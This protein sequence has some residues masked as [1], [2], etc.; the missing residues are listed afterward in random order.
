MMVTERR[1]VSVMRRELML[2]HLLV[3][4]D[5]TAQ[6]GASSGALWMTRYRDYKYYSVLKIRYWVSGTHDE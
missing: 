6:S 4:S 3:L 2:H 5:L 1:M